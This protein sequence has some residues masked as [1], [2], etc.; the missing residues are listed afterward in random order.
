MTDLMTPEIF[1]GHNDVL[2]QLFLNGGVSAA[3]EFL[4]GL[5]GAIDL[6]KAK[7]G[8]FAG[9]FFAI[10]VPSP[11]DDAFSFEDM[12]GDAYDLPLPPLWIG[13]MPSVLRWLRQRRRSNWSGWA[14]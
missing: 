11:P 8:G 9:G 5:P 2:L 7:T 1:D 12:M 3:G 14:H 6:P 13:P 10:Y 4:T